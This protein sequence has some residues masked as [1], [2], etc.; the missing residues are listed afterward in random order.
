MVLW[1]PTAANIIEVR[2]IGGPRSKIHLSLIIGLLSVFSSG[3]IWSTGVR[4][5]MLYAVALPYPR[6]VAWEI[7]QHLSESHS[8]VPI[9][10][11]EDTSVLP[12]HPKRGV[13][14]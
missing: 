10:K 11:N 13:H 6:C 8:E 3:L 14:P 2:T 1:L 5:P 12:V 7:L 4:R 9:L